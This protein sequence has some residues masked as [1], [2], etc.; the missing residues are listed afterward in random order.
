MTERKKERYHH[1]RITLLKVVLTRAVELRGSHH[2]PVLLARCPNGTVHSP[3]HT[4]QP[5]RA[6]AVHAS[7]LAA[8]AAATAKVAGYA[9][10]LA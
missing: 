2:L 6:S 5:R 9:L 10:A 1:A 3:T 8:G 7:E 4:H